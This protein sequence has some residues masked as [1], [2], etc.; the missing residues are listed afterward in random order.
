[1]SHT[2]RDV[3]PDTN[4]EN[5]VRNKVYG[6]SGSALFLIMTI[7]FTLVQLLNLFNPDA[8]VLRFG[9]R[10]YDVL[11]KS[12]MNPAYYP[13]ALLSFLQ[14]PVSNFVFSIPW[15]LIAVGLWLTYIFSRRKR[16]NHIG[17]NIIRITVTVSMC[18]FSIVMAFDANNLFCRIF[19]LIENSLYSVFLMFIPI[20]YAILIILSVF[21]LLK[22]NSTI[23]TIKRTLQYS[24]P[25]QSA[26]RFVAIYC[27]FFAA[28]AL[29]NPFLYHFI[30]LLLSLVGYLLG[31]L[32]Y[33][34]GG[35]FYPL[36]L[37]INLVFPANGFTSLLTNIIAFLFETLPNYCWGNLAP[38]CWG[39]LPTYYQEYL[40]VYY[41]FPT[42]PI[43]WITVILNTVP[44]TLMGILILIYKKRMR[45]MEDVYYTSETDPFID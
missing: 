23:S 6:A 19:P 40:P 2:H 20:T 18:L 44:Y 36:Y 17:L 45:A 8:S 16:N 43:G 31:A 37:L 9:Y 7:C 27:F 41:T 28:Y 5:Q 12:E 29:I 4:F 32:G 11:V 42:S 39:I 14:S 30:C 1:M 26:S 21:F 38:F 35:L 13:D 34:L 15:L 24:I 10:L 25:D 3:A 33:L 22:I